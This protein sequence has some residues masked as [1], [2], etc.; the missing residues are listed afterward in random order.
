MVSISTPQTL[1]KYS[2]PF[3]LSV[4]GGFSR[5]HGQGI[6]YFPLGYLF[7]VSTDKVSVISLSA[8]Y[9]PGS[10]HVS[11][12]LRFTMTLTATDYI[13]QSAL[14]ITATVCTVIHNGHCKIS[15]YHGCMHIRTNEYDRD[16]NSWNSPWPVGTFFLFF[17]TSPLEVGLKLVRTHLNY[18][19]TTPQFVLVLSL[20]LC[21]ILFPWKDI[22]LDFIC[23][24]SVELWGSL[25]GI[26]WRIYVKSDLYE[27]HPYTNVQRVVRPALGRMFGRVLHIENKHRICSLAFERL[28]CICLW[29]IMPP[30]ATKSKNAIL[31]QRSKSRS[32]GHWPCCHLKEH[33]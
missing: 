18:R 14:F 24:D 31:A 21:I 27:Q 17:P 5:L 23:I 25:A 6:C 1:A 13:T 29:N 9:F 3:L 33:H 11:Q 22:M 32:H 19:F 10:W 2:R 28:K 8:I 12:M 30:A 20:S 15:C 7:P 26:C 16:Y 4:G